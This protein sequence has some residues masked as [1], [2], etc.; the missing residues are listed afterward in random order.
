MCLNPQSIPDVCLW[1]DFQKGLTI[2]EN[3]L[4]CGQHHPKRWFWWKK[5]RKRKPANTD[6]PWP[7]RFLVAM[8]SALLFSSMHSSPWC[9][10]PS[11]SP[12][13]LSPPFVTFFAQ[14]LSTATA[15]PLTQWWATGR[16]RMLCMPRESVAQEEK[17]VGQTVPRFWMRMCWDW[18][19]WAIQD[20]EA[21][22]CREMSIWGWKG[23]QEG[24]LRVRAELH[25]L[26]SDDHTT[27]KL[28]FHL[29][30]VLGLRGRNKL[31]PLET[32]LRNR[33]T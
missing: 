9:T 5:S 19:C 7:H 28:S 21:A 23:R 33:C 10:E 18:M 30:V 1:R 12:L 17:Y 13:F 6:S 16:A 20:L 11:L 26:L 32:P 14:A 24:Q 3:M 31:K 25:C 8:M 27:L 2:V 22:D 4:E 29:V 15:V